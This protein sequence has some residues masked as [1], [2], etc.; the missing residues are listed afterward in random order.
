[1]VK[2]GR[3]VKKVDKTLH[4]FIS[5][6]NVRFENKHDENFSISR[7]RNQGIFFKPKVRI[8]DTNFLVRLLMRI[9]VRKM[10]K[11]IG[12]EPDHNYRVAKSFEF[13]MKG[14]S[15][16]DLQ[17]FFDPYHSVFYKPER[18]FKNIFLQRFKPDNQECI[19]CGGENKV[20][21]SLMDRVRS[22]PKTMETG[23]ELCKVCDAE[24]K[25]DMFE[26]N[27]Q[28]KYKNFIKEYDISII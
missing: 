23:R 18:L 22:D 4:S 6:E 28:K 14:R 12:R 11:I 7:F 2:V 19:R 13:R 10:K 21:V 27:N 25:R 26:D 1:M 20:K 3:I 9:H 15:R 24:Y 17:S 5:R 16:A 8:E